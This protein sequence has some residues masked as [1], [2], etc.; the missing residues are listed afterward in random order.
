MIWTGAVLGAALK[1][2]A[3]ARFEQVSILAYLLLGWAGLSPLT[4]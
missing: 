1:L 3:P 4:S 2:L